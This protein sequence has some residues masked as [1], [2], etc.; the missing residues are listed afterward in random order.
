MVNDIK[1]EANQSFI[2]TV[3][4][5]LKLKYYFLFNLPM[6]LLAG[7]KLYKLN[8][9]SAQVS[10]KYKWLNTNPFRSV[11][12]ACLQM[13][14]EFSTG[15]ICM[16][17]INNSPKKMSILVLE[18]RAKFQKKAV[19]K[20]FFNCNDGDKIRQAINESLITGEGRTVEALSIG[21]DETGD[22]I[23]EFYFTWTFKPKK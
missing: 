18:N 22:Q 2:K 9:E 15:I 4:N 20:L 8:A 10:L 5:P 21:T 7:I 3:L 23:G 6:A 17:Y 12:F 13:A 1:I 19:G 16:A 14:A 11:Y